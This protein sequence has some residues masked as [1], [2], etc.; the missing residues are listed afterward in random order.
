VAVLDMGGKIAEGTPD[1]VRANPLVI[2]AYLGE[3]KPEGAARGAGGP[4]RGAGGA[5]RV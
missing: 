5:A 3:T 1:E 2:K 4:A